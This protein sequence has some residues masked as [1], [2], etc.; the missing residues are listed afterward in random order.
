MA[1]DDLAANGMRV[2]GVAFRS[3]DAIP[4]RYWRH[5][6]DLT[7]VGLVAMIDPPRPEVKDAVRRATS[8]AFV[9]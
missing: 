2:L 7:F 1:N 5:E 6:E 8:P 3:L 9:R 4:E